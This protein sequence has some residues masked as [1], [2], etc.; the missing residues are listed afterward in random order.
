MEMIILSVAAFIVAILT[1]F[2]GFGLGTILTPVFMI[3]FPVEVAITLVGIVH[4]F[5][6]ILIAGMVGKSA[7][8]TVLIRFGIPATL[9]SLAGAWLL[10]NI[11][12]LP[13]LYSYTICEKIFEVKPV[14][15][16]IASLL[17]GFALF[18]IIP[19]LKAIQFSRNKLPIGGLLSG[20]FGG[21]S[22]LLGALRSAFLIKS[23]LTKEAFIASA[24][25]LSVF[26]D[27]TRLSVYATRFSETSL[28][29]NLSYVNA[30]TFAALTGSLI[31]KRI[32]K[33]I[34]LKFIQVTIAIMLF[35][36]AIALG[37][38]LL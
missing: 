26:V 33:K 11:S 17:I 6:N 27:T 16:I 14:K 24:A 35:L 15:L 23:G 36:I 22:G 10:M 29:E 5:N 31:G 1:F 3:F 19:S 4:F 32:L 7:D 12:N 9:A 21:L 20:F 18:N 28:H 37:A 34:T 2:S 13:D 8:K 25:V 30:A 38:G